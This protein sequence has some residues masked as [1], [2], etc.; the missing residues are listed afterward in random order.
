MKFATKAIHAG[1]EADPTTGSTITPIY[2]TATYTQEEIGKHKGYEYS[3]TG[4][5]TR[6]ALETCLASL[7]E[8][9]FGLAFASGS[10]A[11]AA[12]L[13]IL[14]PGDH[15]VATDD[16]YGGTYRL[17]EKVYA[18]LGITVTYVDGRY[19]DEFAR[20]MQA[21]TR[22]VWLE[23]P[24]NPLLR[25]VDIAAV[26]EIT[27]ANQVILAVDNTF[28]TPYGQRPLTLGA[29]VV[30]HSTTKYIGGHSDVVGGAM[31]TSNTNLYQA[32]KFYQNAAGAIPGPFDCWLTLRGL[33]TLPIRM[34]QHAE[35]AMQVAEYLAQ[36]PVINVVHYPGLQSHPQ[37]ELAKRQ[38][39]TFGGMV[40]FEIEGGREAANTFFRRLKIFALA[41]SLGGVESLA[42]YPSEMTHGS[43]PREERERRGISAGM[44]RLSVGIE[45]SEDLL[46]DLE[47][48]LDAAKKL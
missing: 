45:D 36:H 4:N 8:G 5:P 11:T 42:C 34:H 38:M 39:D 28:A 2:Q 41:E 43:I 44:I 14:R 25:L 12:V 20:V 7:E 48:A 32:V 15:V 29:D 27:R 18:P 35:N 33:K 37:Y 19:P 24:T 6:T 31:V 16:L 22:L 26:A 40:S 13:S 21:H 17:F 3:R 23:T 46:A 1:Q 47:Q 30:V 9:Q 10:A